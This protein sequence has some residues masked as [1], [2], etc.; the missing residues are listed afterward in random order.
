MRAPFGSGTKSRYQL[1]D[2][3]QHITW[4]PNDPFEIKLSASN[5]ISIIPHPPAGALPA[6]GT[7]PPAAPAP[8]EGYVLGEITVDPAALGIKA[9]AVARDLHY[10]LRYK[11]LT[12][13]PRSPLPPTPRPPPGEFESPHYS[14]MIALEEFV[15]GIPRPLDDRVPFLFVATVGQPSPA[16]VLVFKEEAVKC[17][18][19]DYLATGRLRL[20][21]AV[22]NTEVNALEFVPVD[23]EAA[24]AQLFDQLKESLASHTA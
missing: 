19:G 20:L 22:F 5:F 7:T 3:L 17:G 10:L 16:Q 15:T 11:D 12:G 2:Y 9:R 14:Q 18:L 21:S 6:F 23:C 8:V 1:P 13:P 4:R 24:L